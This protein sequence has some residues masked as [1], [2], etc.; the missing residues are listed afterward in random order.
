MNGTFAH[1]NT[2]TYAHKRRPASN[3]PIDFALFGVLLQFLITH[4]HMDPV[5][6][7]RSQLL[8][9]LGACTHILSQTCYLSFINNATCWQGEAQFMIHYLTPEASL[10]HLETSKKMSK[11]CS[12]L[13]QQAD[14]STRAQRYASS[15]CHLKFCARSLRSPDA[16]IS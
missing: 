6:A 2:H 7:T 13:S 10:S 3:E 14:T 4:S 9:H 8:G 15:L 12:S 5:T 1:K 11:T 16:E